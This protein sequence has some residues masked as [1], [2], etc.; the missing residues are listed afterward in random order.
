METSMRATGLG[1]RRRREENGHDELRRLRVDALTDVIA[2]DGEITDALLDRLRS[3]L[4]DCVRAGAA[5]VI[6]DLGAARSG[7]DALDVM[8]A[9]AAGPLAGRDGGLAVVGWCGSR[10]GTD[11]GVF[12]TQAEALAGVRGRLTPPRRSISTHRNGARAIAP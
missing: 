6:V 4:T 7:G 3:T 10:A 12:S 1:R 2:L 8:L 9:D 11:V 5:F